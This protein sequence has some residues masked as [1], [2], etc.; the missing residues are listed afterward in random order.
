MTDLSTAELIDIVSRLQLRVNALDS[1]MAYPRPSLHDLAKVREEI[2]QL[3]CN[4]KATFE[5]INKK[6]VPLYKS[7]GLIKESVVQSIAEFVGEEIRDERERV[8]E[9]IDKTRDEINRS[10]VGIAEDARNA[11]KAHVTATVKAIGEFARTFARG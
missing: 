8:D 10:T 11:S 7:K 4:L 1:E 2:S 6:F 9:R 5:E 3:E